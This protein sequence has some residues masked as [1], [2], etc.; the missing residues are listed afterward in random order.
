[1][2]KLITISLL[3]ISCNTFADVI[4]CPDKP[5][6]LINGK[7][8]DL[9]FREQNNANSNTNEQYHKYDPIKKQIEND[10]FSGR[11]DYVSLSYDDK[12]TTA[13]SILE[14]DKTITLICTGTY[15]LQRQYTYTPCRNFTENFIAT[16]SIGSTY[17]WCMSNSDNKSFTCSSI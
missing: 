10:E 7:L 12:N 5:E 1:M 9:S 13:R 14:D 4:N 15:G 16:T 2:K 17:K 6:A 3:F 8:W 11:I